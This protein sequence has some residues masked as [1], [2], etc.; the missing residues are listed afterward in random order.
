LLKSLDKEPSDRFARARDMAT[1]LRGQAVVPVHMTAQTGSQYVPRPRGAAHVLPTAGPGGT[2]IMPA[3]T[4]THSRVWVAGVVCLAMI[5]LAVIV[6]VGLQHRAPRTASVPAV[7][8]MPSAQAA[9]RLKG[10]GN[11]S[12]VYNA[13]RYSEEYPEGTIIGQHP[14]PDTVQERGDAVYLAASLGPV[15]EKAVPG[16]VGMT[17]EDALRAV[18]QAGFVCEVAGR[19]PGDSQPAGHVL[20]QEPSSGTMRKPG[21]QVAITVSN[22]PQQPVAEPSTESTA[23]ALLCGEWHRFR[24]GGGFAP[25]LWAFRS[26]HT[27]ELRE[28]GSSYTETGTWRVQDEGNELSLAVDRGRGPAYYRLRFG[29]EGLRFHAERERNGKLI[30]CDAERR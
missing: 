30:W 18:Q 11:F 19:R 1:A 25:G 12:I 6:L 20:S 28:D 24:G 23:D 2:V 7:I 10:A 29:D 15:P 5:G 3:R 26:D 17:E 8:G 27:Y 9:A 22:G 13:G 4:R 21:A 14:R 16:V